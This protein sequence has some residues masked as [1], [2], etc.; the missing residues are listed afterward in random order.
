MD[1]HHVH[2]LAAFGNRRH[3][4]QNVHV[5]GETLALNDF[6]GRFLEPRHQASFPL[7]GTFVLTD[8]INASHEDDHE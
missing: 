8:Q 7:P 5:P 6:T 3:R 4:V 2:A 1:V